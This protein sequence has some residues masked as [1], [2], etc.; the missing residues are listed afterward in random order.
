M[1]ARP[2]GSVWLWGSRIV[3]SLTLLLVITLPWF[4]VSLG[5][6]FQG[7]VYLAGMVLLNLPHGLLE[8]YVNLAQRGSAFRLRYVLG[9]FGLILLFLGFWGLC[10]TLGF[11]L[12]LV[13]AAAKAGGGD[14]S[15]MDLLNQSLHLRY[16][17]QRW[18]AMAVRGGMVMVLPIVWHAAVFQGLGSLMVARF[19]AASVPRVLLVLQE[20]Q[21][22]AGYV[23]FVLLA[24]HCFGSFWTSR[25]DDSARS[26]WLVDLLDTGLLV[27]FF[28]FVPPLLAVGLYFPFWYSA[29]QIGRHLIVASKHDTDNTCGGLSN[30]IGWRDTFLLP[31]LFLFAMLAFGMI[32]LLVP[33]AGYDLSVFDAVA[34]WTILIS[35][36]ALPHVVIGAW[37]DRERGIWFVP[38]RVADGRVVGSHS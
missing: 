31:G 37:A 26:S 8:H 18:L 30:P 7:I 33:N 19:D 29:R 5:L 17:V 36:V 27:V 6:T 13:V 1:G 28:G 25:Q 21:F 23:F 11:M 2:S 12:M 10:P 14:L 4:G 16:R 35:I 38:T 9:F 3:L 34:F 20:M 15:L 32:W 24:A 22:Y